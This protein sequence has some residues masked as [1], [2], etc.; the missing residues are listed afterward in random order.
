MNK[1]LEAKNSHKWADQPIRWL[2][3]V[4]GAFYVAMTSAEARGAG[5]RVGGLAGWRVGILEVGC[6]WRPLC[7][8]SPAFFFLLLLLLLLLLLRPAAQ[9]LAALRG[10]L[11]DFFLEVPDFL[12]RQ[13][14]TQTT[15]SHTYAARML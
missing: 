13:C 9:A 2:Q 11:V 8:F 3:R 10:A 7:C 1:A 15:S 12:P 5:G 4:C 6:R 14:I